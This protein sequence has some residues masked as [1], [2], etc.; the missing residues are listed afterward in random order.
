[1]ASGFF[2]TLKKLNT[3]AASLQWAGIAFAMIA[4]GAAAIIVGWLAATRD[5]FWNEYGWL[6]VVL[7][8]VSVF[9]AVSLALGGLALFKIWQS[10]VLKSETRSAPSERTLPLRTLTVPELMKHVGTYFDSRQ[11]RSAGLKVVR[12]TIEEIYDALR[13]GHLKSWGHRSDVY[14]PHT[15]GPH[16]PRSYIESSFW[17]ANSIEELDLVAVGKTVNPERMWETVTVPDPLRFSRRELAPCYW[18]VVFDTDDA[19][20]KW[21]TKSGW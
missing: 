9:V 18:N 3:A 19:R 15:V 14:P 13:S 7:L 8:A 12:Q 10:G 5:R 11:D 20:F 1:M 6:G 2:G 4:P 21:P 17:S 16:G